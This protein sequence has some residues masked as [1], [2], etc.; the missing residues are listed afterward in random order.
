MQLEV[1][2]LV[3]LEMALGSGA[4]DIPDGKWLLHRLHVVHL[5]EVCL[6]DLW[7]LY[8]F[9]GVVRFQSRFYAKQLLNTL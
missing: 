4:K 3:R 8:I 2:L 7:G 6:E 1:P 9:S 5:P